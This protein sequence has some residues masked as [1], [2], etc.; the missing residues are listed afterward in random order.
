MTNIAITIGVQEYEFL[1]PL[2]Y[3]ANDAKKMRE[4]LLEEGNFDE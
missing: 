3:T 4:F 1:T 2:K